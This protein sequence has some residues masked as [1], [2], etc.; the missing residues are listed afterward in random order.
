[1]TREHV[2]GQ[3]VSKI[4][5]DLAPVQHHAGSLNGLPRDMGTQA[6]YRQTVKNFCASCNNGWMS[7]LED[8]AQ[9][10]LTPLILGQSGTIEVEDQAL[11]AMWAQKTAL[12]SMLLSSEEQRS[13]GYGLA[14]SE[15]EAFY[16]T[17]TRME[18]LAASR[19]WAGRYEGGTGFS[20][21]RVTPL[22]VR[23]PG[24]P[25]P[26]RPQAYATTIV[27]GELVLQSVRFTTP[28]LELDLTTELGMPQIWPSDTPVDWPEGE[29]CTQARFLQFADGRLLRPAI[30]DIELRPWTLA[31]ELPQSAL[32]DGKVKVPT[33]CGKHSFF[34]PQALL[35]E[36]LRGTF[37]A[38]ITECECPVA[39][40]LQ[41]EKDGVH[42]KAA[43]NAEGV[44]AMYEDL[45][46]E[47]L[48]YEDKT[49]VFICKRLIPSTP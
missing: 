41:T 44:S 34:Y 19:V 4:G 11:I 29:L 6:P 36:V 37:Y 27:L 46:G 48:Q 23:I 8:V 38:F 24:I 22:A 17:S 15:Y 3:W 39:Y 43:G 7:A 20:G 16:E 42:C 45:P 26:D 32:V 10:V 31:T 30:G 5:L 14:P 18:P 28:E 9:R 2:F 40:L 47:E 1:M 13:S 49:G 12:T 25:E 35:A 21:V 33:L